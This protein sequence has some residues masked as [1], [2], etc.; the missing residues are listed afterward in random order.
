MRRAICLCEPHVALA[1][2]IGNWKFVY[3]T[4]TTLSKGAKLKFDM[5]SHG[6]LIDW[7]VPS[8]D[9]KASENVI[10]A[11]I[12]EGKP[13]AAKEVETPDSVVPQFEFTL[14]SEL[15]AG[16]SITIHI[17]APAKVNVDAKVKGNKSQ[18]HTQRRKSFLLYIAPKGDSKYEDPEV[19][20]MDIRGNKLSTIQIITPS[21]V[22]KNKRFDVIV[23]FED[24]Y[25]NLTNN[26]HPD[27]LIDLSHEH[28]RE[29]LN[30][31]LFIPETGFVTLPNLYFNDP[32]VYK[33]RL[34][35]LKTG[36]IFFSSPIKCFIDS[37]KNLFWGL[38]HG[39]S[40]RV[41]STEGIESC[42]RHFRDEKALNFFA[43]SCFDS[44]EET[45]NEMWKFLSQHIAEFNEDERFSTFPGLQWR[46]ENHS[47]G[48]RHFLYLK[49]NKP[50]LRQK[51]AKT[52]TL[53]K[54]YKTFSPKELLSIPSFTM[55][56]PTSFNFQDFNPE[57]E[58][59]VEIYNAWGSSECSKDE[60]NLRPIT[61]ATKKS[62][63]ESKEG[64]IQ[65][66]LQHNCRFGFVAGGLDD[67]DFFSTLYESDQVQY[68]P[69]LTA[70]I[71]KAHT[72]DS[73]FEALYNRSCYA[74]TGKRIIVGFYII[75][76]PMGSELDTK[77]KP[78]LVINRHISGYVAGTA[79]LQKVE[80][81]RN[82][83]IIKTFSC[84][85]DASLDFTYDDLDDLKSVVLDGG[86]GKLPF[87]YY[88]IRVYQE[89]KNMAW[90][91]PIWI[92]FHGEMP[93]IKKA[94]KTSKK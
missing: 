67:R 42:L 68:S 74:T 34:R 5:Q 25:G 27:T 31:R 75:G 39:E 15:K 18:T 71:A 53:K 14:P 11:Y 72:R 80:L 30:W 61:G 24:C 55:G 54:V 79:P 83:D 13:I 59:V 92:D 94:K 62:A 85:G 91:S 69:G 33:I 81:I 38:L 48:L 49:D 56:S 90:S 66:A 84:N 29:N 41:D 87:A 47:E 52:T 17:G 12:Q 63:H 45:S 20:S 28:L 46:G 51:D 70:I 73:L 35:N 86:E 8:S 10:Y 82:G 23:R 37:Q 9:L 64:S 22:V 16:N 77:A 4:A 2:E 78:G 32:G 36:E 60:G 26:T 21:F 1:G 3:T 43:T 40:E 6:R 19:F 88:Y 57:Y 44:A 93:S 50:I 7:Q 65:L 76:S 58:R 89:D